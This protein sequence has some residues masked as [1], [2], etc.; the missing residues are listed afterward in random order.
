MKKLLIALS[1]IFLFGLQSASAQ[2]DKVG[3]LDHDGNFVLTVPQN[4]GK[5]IL[6]QH[7]LPTEASPF[8]ATDITITEMTDGTLSLT[9]Y[10]KNPGGHIVKGFRIQCS[11]DDENNLIVKPGNK[12]ERVIGRPF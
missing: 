11:Q 10:L 7:S 12:R 2:S 4:Q 8:E 6:R 5:N 3:Q 1:S 9:G